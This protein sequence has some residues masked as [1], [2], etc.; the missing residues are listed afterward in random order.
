L[1]GVAAAVFGL[2]T[3]RL[4][5]W[6]ALRDNIGDVARRGTLA[7]SRPLGFLP[8]IIALA[9]A[10]V[11]TYQW[12]RAAPIWL[13]EEMIAINIRDRSFTDLAGPLWLGQSAPY[14]WL[15][16]ERAAILTLGTGSWHFAPRRCSLASRRSLPPS[17]LAA[18]G[19]PASPR[20][21][22]RCCAGSARPSC[23]TAL[24]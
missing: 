12:T 7:V 2:L 20:R 19:S 9:S 15:V 8:V 16:V 13:D 1:T 23:T 17:G 24:S 22:S 10:A 4:G 3:W 21:C 18:D 5:D 14:G 6:L 11:D